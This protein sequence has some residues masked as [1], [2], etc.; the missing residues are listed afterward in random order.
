MRSPH[1]L[2]RPRLG[3]LVVAFAAT[4]VIPATVDAGGPHDGGH[5]GRDRCER[6]NNNTYDAL[7]ECVTVRGVRQ[8]LRAFQQIADANGGTRADQ[9]SGYDASVDYVEQRLRKAG[10]RVD[11]VDFEYE[12]TEVTLQQLT[13][14]DATYPSGAFVG[15]GD[16]TVTGTV[17]PVDLALDGDRASSS[18][19]TADDFAGLDLSGPADI[20]LVQRGE[21][22]FGIK[23]LNAEAAGAEAVILFN[24]GDTDAPDRNDLI[25]GTLLP[26]GEAVTIPVVGASFEQGVAL[27]EPGATA[28]VDVQFVTRTSQNVIAEL[29][30][31]NR[32]N[33]VM[34]G[35]HLDSVPE[36]P[37][38]NDNG[39]GSAVLI[40]VA[41]QLGNHKPQNTLRFA[42]WGAEELGLLGSTAWVG[43][44]SQEQLD[45]IALYMNFDMVG[46]PNYVFTVYDA[47]QS[48]FPA[49]VPVPSGSEAVEDTFERFYTW[50]GVPY[51]DTEFSGRSDYQ[52]FIEAGIASSGLFTGA[53][54]VK[55]PEQQAIWGGSAGEWFDPCYHQACDT[56]AN[57][58]NRALNVN[59]DA[60][61]FAVLTYA[62]STEDVNGVPGKRVPGR[63]H[64]IPQ[65]AGPEGTF[66]T[67][68]GGGHAPAAP[69][70]LD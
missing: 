65:P 10:W 3:A 7:L 52:A 61:A 30:G 27:A 62:Y 40:E 35:A 20:A 32:D 18:A 37:G 42:W 31:R 49:P 2:R 24:Q 9:T 45:E 39:S 26:D 64:G 50:R 46:S 17:V 23:A 51:D 36:G 34:A 70:S 29:P 6:R 33:V 1:Q 12:D 69:A 14:V 43:Q 59:S 68:G 5:G 28:L 63:P 22:S 53:E 44:Q 13:P 25:V 41:E 67:D 4:A 15:S 60:I 56:I 54:E 66:P 16:G 8:H 57:V 38:I 47:D 48:T 58:S 55:T 21:C 11:V 19:C